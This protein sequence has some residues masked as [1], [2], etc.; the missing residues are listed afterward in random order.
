MILCPLDVLFSRQK[1]ILFLEDSYLRKSSIECGRMLQRALG[2]L[3]KLF[4]MKRFMLM[5]YSA[6]L[7]D[8]QKNLISAEDICLFDS[9]CQLRI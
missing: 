2:L 6:Q 1:I 3:N 8:M 4:C 5:E 7:V 9:Y